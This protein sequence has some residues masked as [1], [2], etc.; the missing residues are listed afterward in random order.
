LFAAS[1][2]LRLEFA[3]EPTILAWLGIE[4]ANKF[5]ICV[6][7]KITATDHSPFLQTYV[8]SPQVLPGIIFGVLFWIAAIIFVIWVNIPLSLLSDKFDALG[9]DV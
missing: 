5:K 2:K 1:T 9:L 6:L 7:R 8:V 3:K 4:M